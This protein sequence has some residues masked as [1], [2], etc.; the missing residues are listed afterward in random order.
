MGLAS[1]SNTY[2]F[3]ARTLAPKSL[4]AFRNI[5][6]LRGKVC[7][8]MAELHTPKMMATPDGAERSADPARGSGQP[9][10]P[11]ADRRRA[12]ERIRGVSTA[13]SSS[14][15]RSSRVS[16]RI[17]RDGPLKGAASRQGL[18]RKDYALAVSIAGEKANGP[19]IKRQLDLARCFLCRDFF[20]KF[21]ISLASDDC[22]S[23]LRMLVAVQSK[24]D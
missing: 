13:P 24:S 9:R 6:E 21:V 8:L 7:G 5:C 19:T 2:M 16:G 20:L 12:S 10:P 22:L 14:S 23:L 3:A 4:F 17:T 18:S 1:F 11:D 15:A